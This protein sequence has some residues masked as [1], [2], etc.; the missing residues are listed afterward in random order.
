VLGVRGRLKL[1]D[2]NAIAV[3]AV[4]L[5]LSSS[6]FC[7]PLDD[8]ASTLRAKCIANIDTIKTVKF[9]AI[10]SVEN[11]SSNKMS[12]ARA[13]ESGGD[14]VTWDRNGRKL[15][16]KRSTSQ[17][18]AYVVDVAKGTLSYLGP[19][20]A[21]VF[22]E[23][24]D[25][26]DALGKVVPTPRWLWNPSWLI[27]V[28]PSLVRKESG[29]LFI[30]S[31]IN[32]PRREIRL[33]A[34]TGHLLGFTETDA[35]GNTVRVVEVNGWAEYSGVWLPSGVREEIRAAK[36]TLVRNTSISVSAVNPVFG[37]ND[38]VLP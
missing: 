37:E 30:S 36:G 26:S 13:A 24:I 28:K 6:S 27:P 8:E 18:P 25:E 3:F 35:K 29:T 20:S 11:P 22:V 34:G 1:S 33:E 17:A 5:F 19:D 14:A 4:I 10:T 32:H 7:S 38:F 23:D 12:I 16:W 15:K 21:S 2:K 31:S 9:T